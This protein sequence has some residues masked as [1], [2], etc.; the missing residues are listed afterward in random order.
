MKD[1]SG[2]SI[3]ELIVAI[4]I[5][6]T[7]FGIT[8]INLLGTQRISTQDTAIDT[9]IADLSQ[10][11]IKAMTGE[12][13]GE[14]SISSYGI[15]FEPTQYT[16]LKGG[17]FVSGASSNFVV[18]LDS[19]LR[20]Q[21]ITFPSSMVVFDAGSGEVSNFVSSSASIQILN[22]TN[23]SLKTININRHGAVTSVN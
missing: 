21:S 12:T 23:G 18:K 8:A 20:F 7:L 15:Y 14:G 16:L 13:E 11:Q 19:S 4:G 17:V 22:T 6:A 5:F 2:F 1:K 9:L 10:Q 3:P